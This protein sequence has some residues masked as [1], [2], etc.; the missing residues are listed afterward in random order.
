MTVIVKTLPD[1]PLYVVL[2]NTSIVPVTLPKGYKI[3]SPD[4]IPAHSFVLSDALLVEAVEIWNFTDREL[5]KEPQYDQNQEVATN[6]VKK[7]LIK[8]QAQTGFNQSLTSTGR[9][10]KICRQSM[11]RRGMDT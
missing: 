5:D 4:R 2:F 10:L 3:S 6:I 1:R 11:W 8:W 9:N 7:R